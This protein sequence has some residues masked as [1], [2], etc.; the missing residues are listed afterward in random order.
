MA[1]LPKV[2]VVTCVYNGERFLRPAIESILGQTFGDFEYWIVNDS[3][4][5]GSREIAE[6]YLGDP[7]VHLLDTERNIG[8][9]AAAN[10]ALARA[11][12][13]Y[14]ARMD[15]DDLSLPHRLATQVEFLER[16]SEVGLL[17]TGF[18]GIDEAGEPT[19]SPRQCQRPSWE[20]R[21][22]LLFWNCVPH[23]T[24]MF[25]HDVARRLGYY[26]SWRY[27]QDYDL[28]SRMSFVTEVAEVENVCAL[29]R[30][31]SN[32][33]S[34]TQLPAQRAASME[35]SARA[36][37]RVLRRSSDDPS[38]QRFVRMH[39]RVSEYSTRELRELERFIL[40]AVDP[41]C[42]LFGYGEEIRAR[43]T[44][45]VHGQISS[46]AHLQE[47]GTPLQSLLV[48]L[49]LAARGWHPKSRSR[50]LPA[51]GKLVLGRRGT[52]LATSVRRRVRE[53]FW[54]RS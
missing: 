39:H 15:A 12:G 28:W 37:A 17:G 40:S 54:Q 36:L 2:S 27:A 1:P 8:A 32:G 45:E 5:D 7:R 3:S 30:I 34:A 42:G 23:S 6:S 11:R 51:F 14:I 44:A 35:V 41:F 10:L 49:H 22:I 52:H 50:L 13:E 20:L 25:R 24:V 43:V 18:Q 19:G 38:L 26:G 48:Y 9:Y 31:S 46:M 47:S 21:W 16:H 4:T 53:L 33:L 29:Y